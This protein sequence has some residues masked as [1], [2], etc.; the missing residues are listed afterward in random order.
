MIRLFEKGIGAHAF[1]IAEDNE[2]LIYA[3][4]TTGLKSE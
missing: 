4:N 1:V 2:A 3:S